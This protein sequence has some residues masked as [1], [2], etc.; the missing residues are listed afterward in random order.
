MNAISVEDCLAK[1]VNLSTIRKY[2]MKVNKCCGCK[3][4]KS[5]AEASRPCGCKLSNGGR[6]FVFD[7]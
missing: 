5:V 7:W 4:K 6:F 1:R 2:P 3:F